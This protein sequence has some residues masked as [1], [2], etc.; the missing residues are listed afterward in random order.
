MKTE[1]KIRLEF[2]EVK[3][4]LFIELPTK[5]NFQYTLWVHGSGYGKDTMKECLEYIQEKFPEKSLALKSL[6]ITYNVTIDV[7]TP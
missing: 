2:G 3:D 5:T 4:D 1:E 7:K 6:H